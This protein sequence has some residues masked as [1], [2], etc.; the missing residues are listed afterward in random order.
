[1]CYE[2]RSDLRKYPPG[3]AWHAIQFSLSPNKGQGFHPP[4]PKKKTHEYIDFDILLNNTPD[5]QR[6]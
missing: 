3:Q 2:V 6:C 5:V 4:P 1:M